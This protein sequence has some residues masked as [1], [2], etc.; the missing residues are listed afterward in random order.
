MPFKIAILNLGVNNIKSVKAFFLK[1]G[2]I[3]MLEENFDKKIFNYDCLII[4]GNGRFEEAIKFIDKNNTRQRILNFKKLNKKIIGICLGAQIMLDKSEESPGFFGLG[5]IEGEVK[6]IINNNLKLPLLGWYSLIDTKKNNYK[7]FFFN[8]GY[9]A[10]IKQ[11]KMIKLSLNLDKNIT[12]MFVRDN[13]YGIQFHPEKSSINGR[14]II[15]DILLKDEK[16]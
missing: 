9:F 3:H 2:T 5:L 1:Y 16:F 11:K 6:K 4:P 12:A 15:D 8:N 10:D 7:N 14:N 13:I